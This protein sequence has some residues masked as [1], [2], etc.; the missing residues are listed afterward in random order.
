MS[1]A[2]T[3]ARTRGDRTGPPAALEAPKVEIA[4]GRR[5]PKLAV[6]L[7]TDTYATIRVVVERLRRQTIRDELEL[8]LV[9]PS[10]EELREALAFR[11]EFAAVH[12]IEHPLTSLGPARAAGIRAATAPVVFIGETHTYADPGFAGALLEA[13]SGPWSTVTP[14]F[15]NANP[16]GVFSWAAFLSDYGPWGEGPP[17]GSIERVPIHNTAYRRSVLL[18]FG[19]R[20]PSALSRDDEMWQTLRAGGHRSFFQPEA[21]LDHANVSRPWHWVQER[22][23]IGLQ[24]S[25]QRVQ[26]WPLTRRLS[27]LAASF[28]IPA[29]LTHRVLPGFQRA[30][31]RQRLPVMTMP[32]VVAGMILWAIGEV[33][34]Y[35]GLPG[36]IAERRMLEYEV[37]KL[38]YTKRGRL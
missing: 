5:E 26:R 9:G 27:Y 31:R 13:F 6:I 19:D 25:S 2:Q 4:S 33:A 23:H 28:L 11:D 18:E 32:L 30:A 15:A 14:S 21:R 10:L 7:A 17:A 12:I 37:R 29:V 1:E 22:F 8:V 38:A 3:S 35:L 20:L 36:D 34:G 16:E 24:V